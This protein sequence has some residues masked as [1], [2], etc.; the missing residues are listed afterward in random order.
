MVCIISKIGLNIISKV[1]L[2]DER[3]PKGIPIKIQNMTAVKI[4]ARVV[5]LSDHKS[6][7]SMNI[8]PT[9]DIIANLKP[10]VL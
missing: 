1:L 6:T 10:F 9:I 3:I 7:K 8:K 4:I 2:L 5:M